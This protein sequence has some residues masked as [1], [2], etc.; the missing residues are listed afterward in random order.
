MSQYGMPSV[1]QKQISVLP[2]W[3]PHPYSVVPLLTVKMTMSK[4]LFTYLLDYEKTLIAASGCFLIEGVEG[5]NIMIDTGSTMEDFV[6][7]GC[8]CEKI[9]TMPEAL[10]KAAG[11]TPKDIDTLIFTQLHHDHTALAHLFKHAKMIVQQEEWNALHNAPVCYRPVYHP[12][13]L[14][15]C[16][17][18]LID[19]DVLNVF[20]GIHLLYTPGH[21][22]GGQSVVIDTKEGRV[23]IC[24]CC[25]CEDNFNPPKQLSSIWPILVPGLHVNNEDAY[26]SLL[27]VKKRSGFH[28]YAS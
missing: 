4:G 27:R 5:H 14:E 26:E 19:G 17:P 6:N 3:Q 25:C 9:E 24:G 1:K 10:K 12:E 15:G 23:I 7:H 2:A 21:T 20:P 8:S 22:P 28:Y 13:Y 11:L 16:V 18:T